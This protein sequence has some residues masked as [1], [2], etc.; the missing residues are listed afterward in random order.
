MTIT[1]T[2]DPD[3]PLGGHALLTAR[4][5]VSPGPVSLTVVDLFEDRHLGPKGWQSAPVSLGPYA[6][7]EE[8]GATVV[9]VGPEV[10]DRIEAFTALRVTVGGFGADLTWPDT[11]RGSPSRAAL[12]GVGV[13]QRQEPAPPP[14]SAPP[15]PAAQAETPARPPEPEP[16]APADEGKGDK[17]PGRTAVVALLLVAVGAAGAAAWWFF[18]RGDAPVETAAPAAVAPPVAPPPGAVAA[19]GCDA[20]ALAAAAALPPAEGFAAVAACVDA[21]GAEAR[22]AVIEAAARAGV[23]EAIAMIGRWYDPDE[24]EAVGSAF[25]GRD[26]ALA[27]RHYKD[28]LAAGYA[29]AA[30]LLA[31]ACARLD[32][33]ADPTH[34]VAREQFCPRP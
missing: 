21:G 30:P 13:L 31:S 8:G 10:V 20:A 17:A 33:D 1:V 12:G 5:P 24:A 16:P 23:G 27:A 6:A 22:F 18:G 4:G 29:A 9:P 3:H 32:P 2:P 14:R 7:R 19:P 28:A 25:A 26:P 15:P 11:V 34:E